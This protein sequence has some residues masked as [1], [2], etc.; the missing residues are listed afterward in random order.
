MV[1]RRLSNLRLL[2]NVK[3]KNQQR[4]KPA[5]V[6]QRNEM[7]SGG[8]PRPQ[9]VSGVPLRPQPVSDALLKDPAAVLIPCVASNRRHNAKPSC[10]S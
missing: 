10:F 6:E 9:P 8:P 7:V 2:N 4:A 3:A 1:L 5:F